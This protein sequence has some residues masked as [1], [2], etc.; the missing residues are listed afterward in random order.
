M[1]NTKKWLTSLL[2]CLILFGCGDKPATDKSLLGVD[3]HSLITKLHKPNQV[4]LIEL[5]A[6][7]ELSEYRSNLYQ[8]F[9]RLKSGDT[10]Q[11][12][13]LLWKREDYTEVAWLKSENHK[14]IVIDHLKWSK[15][16]SF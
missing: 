16:I 14:W 3:E 12:K 13:E 10:V 9:P 2:V 11:I 4:Q 6:N 8:L 1:K 5:T 7:S 15:N